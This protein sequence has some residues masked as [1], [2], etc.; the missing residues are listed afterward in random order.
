MHVFT[1]V[2]N[3]YLPKARVLGR[4]LK[5]HNPDVKFHVLL[6]DKIPSE[7]LTDDEPFD[8]IIPIDELPLDEKESWFFQHD[9]VELCTAVKGEGFLEIVRRHKA[10]KVVYLDPD[11]VVF[12][13]LDELSDKLDRHSIILT[14]HQTEPETSYQAII[15]NELSILQHGVFNLGFLAVRTSEE[16]MAF[17]QWWADRLKEFCEDNIPRGLFTDQKWIDLAPAYYTDLEILRDPGYNVA[18]WNLTHRVARGEVGGDI[19]INDRPLRIFHFSGFDSGAHARMLERY[20]GRSP[21]LND[22]RLWYTKECGKMGEG[23]FS[24]VNCEYAFYNSGKP[25]KLDERRLYR[26]R[27]DLREKFPTPRDDGDINQS[28]RDWF[29]VN[30]AGETGERSFID[31]DEK[32]LRRELQATYNELRRLQGSR[33]WKLARKIAAIANWLRFR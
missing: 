13:S 11:M 28:Y 18:T 9:V 4:S 2:N 22:L 30:A 6:A 16:G 15:D 33:S 14:P 3:R 31:L 24:K 25:I 12:S 5:Q 1:S 10:D 26:V 19:T 20:G 23:V 27:K 32:Q 17:L 7:L 8:S 29:R 21:I